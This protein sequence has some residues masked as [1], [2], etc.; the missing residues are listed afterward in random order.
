MKLEASVCIVYSCAREANSVARAVTPDNA[1]TTQGML[2]KVWNVESQLSTLL[3]C[4]KSVKTFI[5]TLDDLLACITVA[6]KTITS[7]KNSHG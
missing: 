5:S 2:L 7:V 3:I 4:E 1:E 6:E